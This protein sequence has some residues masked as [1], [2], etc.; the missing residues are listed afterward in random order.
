MDLS[1]SPSLIILIA[2]C[3]LPV[4]IAAVQNHH[5]GLSILV[6]NLFLGWTIVGWVV[7]LA[8]AVSTISPAKPT[9]GDPAP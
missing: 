1:G 7:A 5:N 9:E 2:L 8:W 6:V 4:I 3:F